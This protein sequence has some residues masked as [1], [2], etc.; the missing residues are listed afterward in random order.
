[1]AI[2]DVSPQAEV[3]APTQTP[4]PMH[5]PGPNGGPPL[6]ISGVSKFLQGLFGPHPGSAIASTALGLYGTIQQN[7]ATN[8]ATNATARAADQSLQFQKDSLAAYSEAQ[9]KAT[10]LQGRMYDT[11]RNDL[12][13]YRGIGGA[14]LGPLGYA[15]GLPGYEAGNTGTLPATAPSNVSQTTAPTAQPSTGA[16]TA[17]STAQSGPVQ[18]RAPDGSV[19]AVPADQV[20]HYLS[21]GA[22]RV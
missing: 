22:T 16:P 9:Q 18:L 8:T 7:K 5:N 2:V 13:P 17:S 11:S 10:A 15:M 1:M 19:Q 14:A 3:P 21:R 4:I 12:A 6:P 20:D